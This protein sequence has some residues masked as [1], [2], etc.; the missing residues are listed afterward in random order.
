MIVVGS[1]TI[2]SDAVAIQY[3]PDAATSAIVTTTGFFF[4]VK[5]ASRQMTSDATSLPPGLSM[6]KTTASMLSS[7]LALSNASAMVSE[8]ITRPNIASSV[9]S[10]PTMAPIP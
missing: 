3:P 4:R 6:R 1:A 2:A 5:D 9:L 7:S 10:P 8:P